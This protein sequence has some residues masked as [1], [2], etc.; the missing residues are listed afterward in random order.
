MPAMPSSF[1]CD[2]VLGSVRVRVGVDVV[3]VA[4]FGSC[5][6]GDQQSVVVARRTIALLSRCDRRKVDAS[7]G[8]RSRRHR[9]TGRR[10]ILTYLIRW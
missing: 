8:T 10:S 1:D 7:A 9:S 3:A 4:R 5:A 6:R 2:A